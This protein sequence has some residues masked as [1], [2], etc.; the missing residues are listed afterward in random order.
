MGATLAPD[1][2]RFA[3]VSVLLLRAAEAERQALARNEAPPQFFLILD[4]MNLARVEH[5]LSDFLSCMET[6]GH[7][8]DRGRIEQEPLVLH[9]QETV[10]ATVPGIDGTSASVQVPARLRMPTNVYITGT[11]NVDEM[12]LHHLHWLGSSKPPSDS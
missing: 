6:R 11:V 2:S 1:P 7:D 3:F 9:E 4:E 10:T 8:A 12:S 5:Y